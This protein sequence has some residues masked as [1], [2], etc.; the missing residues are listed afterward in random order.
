MSNWF[1]IIS[2]KNI[3]LLLIGFVIGRF[4]RLGKN[5]IKNIKKQCQTQQQQ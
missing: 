1:E 4:W 2:I 3:L 5:I